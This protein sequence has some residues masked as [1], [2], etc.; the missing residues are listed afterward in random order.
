MDLCFPQRLAR[1]DLRTS[2]S[3]DCQEAFGYGAFQKRLFLLLILASFSVVCQTSIATLV[4]GDVDHWCKRPKGLNISAAEWKNIAIPLEADG[5]LSQCRVYERC[6]PPVHLNLPNRRRMDSAMQAQPDWWFNECLNAAPE[7]ANDTREIPC[8]EWEYDVSVADSTAVVTWDLVCHRRLI[9][10][11]VVALQYAG[12]VLFLV[13]SGMFADS[14]SRRSCLVASA[15]ALLTTT[16]CTF[17]ASTYYL[18]AVARFLS[19][20]FV[21]VN[22]IFS[23]V[24]PFEVTTHAH[25]PQ[26]VILWQMVGIL[27]AEV[28]EILM[29]RVALHWSLKQ[30]VF[31]APT[32]LLLPMSLTVSESPRWLVA[33]GRLEEAEAVMMQAAETNNFPLPNTAALINKLREQFEAR[34]CSPTSSDDE[35]LDSHSLRRRVLAMFVAYFSMTFSYYVAV[36]ATAPVQEAWI[37]YGVVAATLLA[38]VAMYVLVTGIA[39]VTVMD[40]CL[41]MIAVID[42]LLSATAGA[43]VATITNILI[44]LLRGVSLAVLIHILVF[45]MEL[46]PSAVRSGALCW[47]FASGRVGALFASVTFVLQLNGRVD[48]AF[49]IAAFLL[50]LSLMVIRVLPR[51]T[52]VEQAKEANLGSSS[53]RN[54]MEH[55]RR[56]LERQT[57]RKT[58]SGST[59]GP[60]SRKSLT[61]NTDVSHKTSAGR[62]GRKLS[63]N[64]RLPK[65]RRQ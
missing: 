42:C 1:C 8:E 17:L 48:V 7:A 3:F 61:S 20:G 30:L 51:T 25:R 2:E 54:T 49:A 4:F 11:V 56:T 47:V 46:F 24:I 34:T 50:F 26:Q 16:V 53:T 35:M 59:E 22:E 14:L 37:P 15:A 44:V 31:L 58:R 43:G 18:Y 45:V 41:V 19:G 33:K 23:V 63:Q 13:I 5:R 36:F 57:D 9:S 29:R 28:W 6:M 12:A 38:C 10:I 62:H 27:L 65:S 21:A 60:K 52:M 32:A 39:L 40:T 64:L 55:M